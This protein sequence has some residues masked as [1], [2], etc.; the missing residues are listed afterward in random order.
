[1]DFV[2]TLGR[3]YINDMVDAVRRAEIR[4]ARHYR[5]D[6]D[7]QQPIRVFFGNIKRNRLT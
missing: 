2:F 5:D 7:V 3:T 4:I 1:M 6:Y